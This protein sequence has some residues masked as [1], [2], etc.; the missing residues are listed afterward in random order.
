MLEPISGLRIFTLSEA[1]EIL[2]RIKGLL[3]RMKDLR[4]QIVS[5]QARVDIEEMTGQADGP[6]MER[7]LKEIET[8]VHAFH[9]M[10]EEMHSLGCELKDL[11]QG[12]V[13][14]Y[15]MHQGEIVYLCWKE[16]ETAVTHWHKLDAGFQGRQ[17][18]D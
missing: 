11:D 1:N 6:A 12:L 2:P 3:S 5:L 18:L 17:K 7:L 16:G 14:F 13:D 4:R 15:G 10:M 8:D 9:K